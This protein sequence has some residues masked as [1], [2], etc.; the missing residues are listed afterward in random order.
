M[1]TPAPRCFVCY[2]SPLPER[3]QGDPAATSFMSGLAY[4]LVVLAV[5]DEGEGLCD[6]HR[7]MVAEG[8]AVIEESLDALED[9]GEREMFRVTEL[10]S[11]KGKARA[12]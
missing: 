4:G 10:N 5:R 7:P 2:P 11:E 9:E 6:L 3:Y 8:L 12:N 1:P